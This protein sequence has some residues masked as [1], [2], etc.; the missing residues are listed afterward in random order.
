MKFFQMGLGSRSEF[1]YLSSRDASCYAKACFSMH[2]LPEPMK[3]SNPWKGVL[4]EA[5]PYAFYES[6]RNV[7]LTLPEAMPN[8]TFILGAISINEKPFMPFT[9][10]E[11]MEE[12]WGCSL[13]N[14]DEAGYTQHPVLEREG[15]TGT[16]FHVATYSVQ[17]LIAEHGEPDFVVMDLEGYEL[18]ILAKMLEICDNITAYQVEAHSSSDCSMIM[19]ML[20]N[21]GYTI[22]N[23]VH[24]KNDRCEMQAIRKT[25]TA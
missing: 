19:H 5:H 1:A 9:A 23:A 11:R 8:L 2:R 25:R 24:M 17:E 6:Y 16:S 12:H 14:I 4:L 10:T 15:F 20:R 22:V 3:V 18:L 7:Q 21:H 13:P